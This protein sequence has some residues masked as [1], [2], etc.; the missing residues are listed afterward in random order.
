MPISGVPRDNVWPQCRNHRLDVGFP[1]RSRS[2]LKAAKHVPKTA[3]P[4][5]E[6]TDM[7]CVQNLVLVG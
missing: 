7:N 3:E 1:L 4:S 5:D 2:A 6:L